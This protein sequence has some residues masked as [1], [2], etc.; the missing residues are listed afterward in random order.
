MSRNLQKRTYQANGYYHIF[1]RGN[2]K[3]EIFHDAEDYTYF[4]NLF[5]CYLVSNSKYKPRW[6]TQTYEDDIRLIAY[7][8]M[9]NHFHTLIQ[10]IPEKSIS[11]FLQAITLKYTKYYN[12]KYALVGHVFQGIFKARLV[13]SDED[14]LY[15]SRYIH[16]NAADITPDFLSY[17]Y[18]S[19]QFFISKKKQKPKWLHI[20]D[21]YSCMNGAFGVSR[22]NCRNAYKKY[23]LQ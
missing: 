14:L 16:K 13:V 7:C 3:K 8:L 19:A 12:K 23:L 10:Q 18:S 15:V 17:P 2:N 11:E 1:N 22:S 5:D 6:I 4:I 21:I 20:D 9:P